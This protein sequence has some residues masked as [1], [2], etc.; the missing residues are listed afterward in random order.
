VGKPHDSMEAIYARMQQLTKDLLEDFLLEQAPITLE[1]VDDL[2]QH[3]DTN[4]FFLITKGIIHLTYEGQTLVS[5]DEGD[6]VG[7][8]RAFNPSGPIR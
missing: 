2:Y 5:V 1:N 7:I 8:T 3:F 4:Q 6:R